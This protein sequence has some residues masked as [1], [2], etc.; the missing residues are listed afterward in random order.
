MQLRNIQKIGNFL[1]SQKRDVVSIIDLCTL[2]ICG[3]ELIEIKA[4]LMSLNG[5]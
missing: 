4:D 2:F 5:I 3:L 1:Q